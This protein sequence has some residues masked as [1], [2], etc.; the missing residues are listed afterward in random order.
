MTTKPYASAL[1]VEGGAL[2]GIHTAGVMDVLMR[3]NIYLPLVIGVSAGALNTYNYIAH[4]KGRSAKI[5]LEYIRDSRY[6]DL[7]A[8]PRQNQSAFDFDFMFHGLQEFLPFD[9]ETFR[10][11][12][13]EFVV[14]ATDVETGEPVY[15]AKARAATFSKRVLLPQACL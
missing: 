2:R 1:V 6:L 10:N 14:V 3:Y 15:F 5:L 7:K 12:G 13:Q 8:I 11:G 9:E 4:Q